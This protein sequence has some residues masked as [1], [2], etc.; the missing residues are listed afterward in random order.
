MKEKKDSMTVV[1]ISGPY[2]SNKGIYG[3]AENI[4]RA[5]QVAMKY[6]KQ[7]SAVICPHLNSAFMD[8]VVSDRIFLEGDKEILKRCD[9]IV[10][11]QGWE[12]SAGASAELKEARKLKKKVIFD[13]V[14][15]ELHYNEGIIDTMISELEGAKQR[16][17]EKR[18]G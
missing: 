7:G 16:L 17:R 6:W 4:E 10:M 9:F 11:M 14:G 1:F 2:R 12:K 3:V 5:K 8:G 15:T 13:N 18:N